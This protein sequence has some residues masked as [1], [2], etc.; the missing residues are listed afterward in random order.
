VELDSIEEAVGSSVPV[1]EKKYPT[2]IGALALI[3]IVLLAVCM[4]LGAT[5]WSATFDFLKGAFGISGGRG[6][7][8]A[9]GE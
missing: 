9:T 5:H 2:W 8:E 3:V 4:A 1:Q 6:R 7:D